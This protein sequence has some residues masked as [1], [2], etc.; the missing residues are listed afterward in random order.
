VYLLIR[1]LRYVDE[2]QDNLLIDALGK[3]LNFIQELT[4]S[5]LVVLRNLCDNPDGLFWAGDTAQVRGTTLFACCRS[6]LNQ[7][8]ANGG[9]AFRFDDLKAFLHRVEVFIFTRFGN[10]SSNATTVQIENSEIEASRGTKVI[11]AHRELP[12][13][14]RHRR[15]R[16]V[17]HIGHHRS[18]PIQHR[19]N[20]KG[21]GDRERR[22]TDLL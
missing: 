20:G 17:H 9:A 8:I 11:R 3:P 2:A 21:V 14:R 10:S 7:T 6:Q 1:I 5:S 19:C 16:V 15:L 4:S 12:L 22:K 18:L 13:A